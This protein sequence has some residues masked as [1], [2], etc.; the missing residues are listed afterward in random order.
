MLFLHD[1]F[2]DTVVVENGGIMKNKYWFISL[3]LCLIGFICIDTALAETGE[4]LVDTAGIKGGLVVH[5]G[6]GDGTLTATL[7]INDRYLVH[8]L[9]TNPKNIAKA[10]EF[11]QSLGVYGKV[12][13]DTFDGEHLPFTDNLVNLLI[14]EDIG[15]VDMTEIMR[16][17]CPNGVA[18]IE[19]NGQWIRTVK[20]RP[21]N[22]DEWPHFLHDAGKNAVAQDQVVGP[23][24]T[25]QWIASP[26]WLRSHE[27]PSGVQSQVS[28]GGRLFYIF[29]E[30][31]VGITDE[32]LPDRWSIV[33]RDAFN[34]IELWR[35]SVEPWGWREWARD[36]W[37]GKDWTVVRAGRVALPNENQCRLVVDGDRLYATLGYN[38]PLSILDA[39]NGEVLS[40]IEETLGTCEILASDGV[41]LA[42]VKDLDSDAQKRRGNPGDSKLVAIDGQTGKVLWEE[43][44]DPIR[45]LCLAI[46][47][48][49]VIYHS[50]G[51][52]IA[53]DLK[54]GDELWRVKQIV[55]NATTLVANKGIVLV[56]KDILAVYDGANGDLLWSKKVMKDSG[57]ATVDLFVANGLV[58]T[59]MWAVDENH[60][61]TRKSAHAMTVGLDPLTGD[62]KKTIYVPNL[63]SPE[64]HHRCYRNK[65]TERYMISAME[66]A[67]FMDLQS[68]DHSQNNWLRGAC[69]LGVMPCNGLLYVPP[70][71][72]F[73]QPGAK[74]LGYSAVGPEPVSIRKDIPDRLRLTKGPAYDVV[75]H[76]RSKASSQDWPTFRHD[77]ARSGSIETDVSPSVTQAWKTDLGDGLTAP[78]AANGKVFVAAGDEH[79]LFALDMKSGEKLWKFTTGGRI[80]SPPTIHKGLVLAGSS[81]GRVYCLRESDG[82]LVWKFMAAPHDRRIGHLDQV[83][84]AWPVHGSVLV[85][86]GIAYFTAGRSSYI[87]GGIRLYGLDPASGKILHKGLLEGPNS[88]DEGERDY[89]FYIMGANSDVLVA[90][91]GTLFMRQKRL[92]PSLQEIKPEVLSSKGE[93]DVGLH[94]FSTS[95]LLDGSWYNRTFW[96]YTKRWPSFQL[97]NQAPKSG[98][99]LV[100]GEKNTYGVKVFYHR[101]THSTMFFPGKE[102]YLLFADDNDNEPQIVGEEGARKPLEW[103]PQS[104]FSRG[105]GREMR[106]LDSHAFGDDKMIGYTRAEPPKWAEWI[107]IRIRAMVKANDILFVAGPPDRFDPEDPFASF[108]GRNGARLAAVSAVNGE[109]LTES[110]IDSL[111]VFDGLI[112]AQE[113]LFMSLKNGSV[114]SYVKK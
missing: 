30:G 109:K 70:D 35:R 38:A 59:G 103:L 88:F 2:S 100:V 67:E 107:K 75:T 99:L 3:T 98:Q 83:E 72:C 96:M 14:S 19:K 42:Y 78:V 45:S 61:P 85:H 16:V 32:R 7:R 21:D 86:E 1:I 114:V 39:A 95:G 90:E 13:V 26:L 77:P 47:C 5:L 55:K 60:K 112:A 6:C 92:T 18:L 12:S 40:T 58:W 81:D 15:D 25:L 53:L 11:I 71:Q 110:T 87:D 27:T 54:K 9:D 36:K 102:G 69:K 57:S 20:P 33:C 10:R 46:D 48:G 93:R 97:V 113:R 65:A 22:I 4:A 76:K 89:A 23:P 101:N 62:V 49:R 74:L 41:V 51:N 105:E 44:V 17:L 29:D 68:D 84:S 104:D 108:E 28:G 52:L 91:G 80:D 82:E 31:L 43:E 24:R 106:A 73:C 63:R 79:T 56:K 111:P 8:G 64:H 66:G 34:G 94:V 37:E 50:G